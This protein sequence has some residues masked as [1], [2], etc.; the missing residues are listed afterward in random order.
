MRAR[1]RGIALAALLVAFG[2]G[3]CVGIPTSG[4]VNVGTTVGDNDDTSGVPLP[5]GPQPDSTQSEILTDFMQAATSPERDYEIAK[6][7]LTKEAAQ[8]WDP[9]K[10]V[11]IREGAATQIEG[12]SDSIDY[13]VTTKAV[14]N[15]VGLYTEDSSSAT[16]DLQFGFV[17]VDGQWR[18][19]SLDNGT[20]V[21]RSNFE[22]VFSPHALY[23]FDPTYNFLIPDVRWFPTRSSVQ[24]RVVG[25]LLLGPASWLQQGATV[26]AFPQGTQLANP[27]DIRSGLA[28]VDLSDE[29]SGAKDL[30]KARMLQQ[31]DTSLGQQATMTVRGAPLPVA[32]ASAS[33]AQPPLPDGAA[34]LVVKGKKFGF[35]PE[36]SA[37]GKV[38]GQV[39]AV[40]PRAVSLG[41]EKT[42]AAVL[43]KEGVYLASNDLA[44]AKLV[45]S[46]THLIAPSIDIFHYVWSVPST[47]GSAIQATGTDGTVHPVSSAIPRHTTIVSLEVSRDGARIL[48]YLNTDAG[49]RLRVAGILRHGGV[50][51]GLGPML[52]LPVTSDE[53]IDAT[54][55]DDRTVAALSHSIIGSVVNAYEIGG[56]AV[57]LGTANDAVHIVGGNGQDQLRVLTSDKRLLQSRTS[58]WQSTGLT[59][60]VLATQQ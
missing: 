20:V 27:V 2:L 58:G 59:A 22:Q 30:D 45:D 60:D 18:I 12:S 51:T 34:P 48:L 57:D 25:A 37:I 8:T 39:A 55:M 36:L 56:P 42:R 5:S 54:W 43:G 19:G 14:I 6:L 33:K 9:N 26:T 50:P 49:P 11:L 52:D 16:Q 4:G 1:R 44:A 53:P 35:L 28:I 17:K 32:D 10:S 7:Y 24:T 15:S 31:L 3:G 29:A 13:S 47:D 41:R 40:G 23:F 38:S 21:S 46:R